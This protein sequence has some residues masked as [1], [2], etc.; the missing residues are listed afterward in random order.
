M[1]KGRRSSAGSQLSPGQAKYVL[2]RLIQ[3]RRVSAGD[4]NRYVS[5]MH[6]EIATLEQ[7]L[8]E[9]KEASGAPRRGPGRPPAA[10]GQQGAAAA[11]KSGRKRGGKRRRRTSAITAQQL[12]SRQLQGRYLGLIRQIAASKRAPFQK[13]ARD[14]G[15][16]AAIKEMQVALKK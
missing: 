7:Q 16:E 12:A 3:D 15:R 9:L 11:E 4:V 5:D 10:A 8:A 6:R 14:K 2:G 13:T 1:P